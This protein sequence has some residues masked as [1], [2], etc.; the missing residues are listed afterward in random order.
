M[1]I[2]TRP[3]HNA[4]SH[5]ASSNKAA[6][7]YIGCVMVNHVQKL[8]MSRCIVRSNVLPGAYKGKKHSTAI[9]RKPNCATSAPSDMTFINVHA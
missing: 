3:T 8:L 2:V 6:V 7:M 1:A 5:I 4:S 9:F